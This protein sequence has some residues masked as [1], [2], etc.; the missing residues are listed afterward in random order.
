MVINGRTVAVIAGQMLLSMP[1]VEAD[2]APLGGRPRVVRRIGDLA[3]VDVLALPPPQAPPLFVRVAVSHVAT[4][5]WE[6]QGQKGKGQRD[7]N[8][9]PRRSPAREYLPISSS[10]SSSSE[11]HLRRPLC[12]FLALRWVWMGLR[13]HGPLEWAVRLEWALLST[14]PMSL[15]A[16]SSSSSSSATDA[17][18]SS[19]SELWMGGKEPNEE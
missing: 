15:P 2:F 10:L 12:H 5:L 19:S 6:R 16:S 11:E 1:S 17:P 13:L 4:P 3:V 9:S 18:K 14:L 8:V 7:V